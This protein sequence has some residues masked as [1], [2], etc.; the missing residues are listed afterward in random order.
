MLST[1][2]DM[3]S[4]SSVLATPAEL[5]SKDQHSIERR[6]QDG[7]GGSNDPPTER[8]DSGG[9]MCGHSSERCCQDGEE[10]DDVTS[11]DGKNCT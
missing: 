7:K 5:G 10:D 8:A 11:L 6:H 4:A 2:L 1:V 9:H 3:D